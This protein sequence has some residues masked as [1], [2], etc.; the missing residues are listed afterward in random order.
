MTT[1]TA[2]SFRRG[3]IPHSVVSA[4][5]VGI[6]ERLL[7]LTGSSPFQR[8]ALVLLALRLNSIHRFSIPAVVA[9]AAPQRRDPVA[10][11]P[12][13]SGVAA[14]GGSGGT[15]AAA[16]AV[17]RPACDLQVARAAAAA[18]A[19]APARSPVIAAAD[20]WLLRVNTY[21]IPSCRVLLW[22]MIRRE[23]AVGFVTT[24]SRTHKFG[25][26]M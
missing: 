2:G 19:S 8:H 3:A 13:C 21:V 7:H 14:P 20:D 1:V 11:S 4:I 23:V 22:R 15:E 24:H 18:S 5:L 10:G 12:R 16:T 17:A 9:E 6:D 26:R 25:R